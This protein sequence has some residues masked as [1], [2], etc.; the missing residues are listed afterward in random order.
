MGLRNSFE[1]AAGLVLNGIGFSFDPLGLW[2]KRLVS[3][4]GVV[5]NGGGGRFRMGSQDG[6]EW[7]RGLDPNGVAVGFRM[8]TAG[9]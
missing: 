4:L 5:S 2:G 3:S 6:F 1:W 8:E 9:A 7:G